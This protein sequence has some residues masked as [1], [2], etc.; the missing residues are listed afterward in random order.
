MRLVA[1]DHLDGKIDCHRDLQSRLRYFAVGHSRVAIAES[2]E[3]A[4]MKDGEEHR[5]AGHGAVIVEIAA[6]D[7]EVRAGQ[8]F[9]PRRRDGDAAQHRL[10]RYL[11]VLERRRGRGEH[12]DAGRVVQL[13]FAVEARVVLRGEIVSRR[14]AKL[15]N[16]TP[17][18]S[19]LAVWLD[20]DQVDH[21]R[22]ARQCSFHI[23]RPD[24]RVAAQSHAF[25]V[26]IGSR[27]I[28]RP[29]VHDVAREDVNA[30]FVPGVVVSLKGGGIVVDLARFG[31]R[32]C[33]RI[34][35][36]LHPRENI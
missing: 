30:R 4:R 10:H 11:E 19:R 33:G 28:G 25:Q 3:R 6:E 36:A 22:V 14:D 15:L 26:F 35:F 8:G 24:V 16:S 29:G 1:L 21:Q 18:P 13:V 27:G 5:R 17:L 2:E 34:A 12:R 7:A 32:R 20:L 31:R 23:N 9:E